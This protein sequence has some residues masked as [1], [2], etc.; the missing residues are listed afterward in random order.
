VFLQTLLRRNPRF[1]EAAVELHQAGHIPANSCVLDLDTI[2]ANT[3]GL[4][5][6]AHR[7]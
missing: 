5:G 3:V 7:L 6:E 2:Q 1:V 4:C